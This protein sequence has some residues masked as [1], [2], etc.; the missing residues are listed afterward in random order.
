MAANRHASR[1]AILQGTPVR[2]REWPKWPRADAGTQRHLLDVL[3][4]SKWTLTGRSERSWSYEDR[5]A[6][7]FAKYIGRKYCVPCVNG[8]AGLTLA[9][10]ASGVGFGEEVIVAGLTW[11]ACA[12]SICYVNAIPRIV[13]VDVDTLCVSVAAV[14]AAIT[15]RTRAV[16]AP[17]MYSGRVDVPALELLC[18]KRGIVLIEDASQAHGAKLNGQRVGSYGNLSIFSMQQTKLLCSGEGGACLTDDANVAT[19]LEQLRADGRKR[20]AEASASDCFPEMIAAGDVMGRNYCLS[21]FHAAILC[22]RLP[23]LDE[24]NE[25]RRRNARRLSTLIAQIEGVSIGQSDG[26]ESDGAV[27]YKLPLRL[28]HEGKAALDPTIAARALTTELNLPVGTLD[29]PL[30][31][32]PLYRPH[33]SP[34]IAALPIAA[35]LL[36]PTQFCLPNAWLAWSDRVALPHSALLGDETDL[37]DIVEAISRILEWREELIVFAKACAT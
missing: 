21:E 9:L 4:S 17:H 33:T 12:S 35:H 26:F 10:L 6:S 19:K 32:N 29:R 3:H 2:R 5:F 18:R 24:E 16:I 13:D 11:V 22:A 8:S 25:H 34:Q 1:P 14:E 31:N 23:R 15:P 28:N 37:N 7:A 36:D 30:N 27:F 20:V